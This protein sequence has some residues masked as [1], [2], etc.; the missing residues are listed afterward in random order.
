MKTARSVSAG[1]QRSK[2]IFGFAD[3]CA[4]GAAD[5][6]DFRPQVGT[7]VGDWSLVVSRWRRLVSSAMGRAQERKLSVDNNSSIANNQ[8]SIES[9]EWRNWQTRGTQNPV[10]FTPGVGSIP[11]S[12]NGSSCVMRI[13]CRFLPPIRA[14]RVRYFAP[15]N[16]AL[17]FSRKTRS[18]RSICLVM[19]VQDI[20]LCMRQLSCVS[21]EDL[22]GIQSRIRAAFSPH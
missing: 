12:G 17:P 15:L 1:P 22:H 16:I 10:R 7:V 6:I 5:L 13:A 4:Q 9:P 20:S 14:C 2:K 19:T 3:F 21:G 18:V 8:Q 11:T